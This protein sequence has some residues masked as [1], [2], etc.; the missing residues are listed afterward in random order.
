MSDESDYWAS[1]YPLFHQQLNGF[2]FI[3]NPILIGY[4]LL[5]YWT[6]IT[7]NGPL[8]YG[9]IYLCSRVYMRGT[10]IAMPLI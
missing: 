8:P 2:F 4:L 5:S 1:E 10:Q 9:P 7:L 3:F 6:T